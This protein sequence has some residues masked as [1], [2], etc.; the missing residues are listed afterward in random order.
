[1]EPVRLTIGRATPS[2]FHVLRAT[3]LRGRIFTDAEAPM[4]GVGAYPDPQVVILSWGLWQ[5]WYGGRDD[6]IG[7]ALRIDEMPVTIVGVMPR[8][9]AFPIPGARAWLP[10]PIGAVKDGK[11]LRLQ[12][13]GAL[14]RLAPQA[15][16][17]QA[18][19]E[20]TAR[21]R[22]APDPGMTAVAMFGSAAPSEISV[23]PAVAAMTADVRPAIILLFAAVALLLVTVTANVGSL[24][25]AR[26]TTRR[27]EVAVRAAIGAG[28]SRLLRQ[29]LTESAVIGC[30]GGLLGLA[31][32]VALVS[33]LPA[34]LPADFP[35]AREIAINL[36]VL[37]C[38]LAASLVVSAACALFPAAEASRVDLTAA[39]AGDSAASSG[40]AWRSRSG[41]LRTVIMAVQVAV[42]CLVLVG[43][44][45]L[46]RSF[47][48][49]MQADRGYD[50]VNV[51]TARVDLPRRYTG[52][53][54][55][56]FADAV[57]DRLGAAPGVVA[58]AAGNALPMVTVG[59]NFGFTMPSPQDPSLTLQV[60]TMVRH[61]SP[62]YFPAMRLRLLEGRL[63]SDADTMGTRPVV[64]VN[65]SFAQ[66]YL[67]ASPLGRHLPLSF[68]EGH[69]TCD[70]V[71]IV[72]DMRQG[73]VTEPRAAEV[74]ASY[75]QHPDRLAHAPLILLA[76]TA[77][78]PL[79]QVG[80]LREAVRVQDRSVALDSVMTLEERVTTSLA[81]PRI[82]AVLLGAFAVSALVVAAVG[83]FGVLS[84]AVAQRSR[85][86]GIRTALGARAV[87]V[88]RLVLRHAVLMASA[89]IAAGLAAAAVVVRLL[90]GFLFGVSTR[91]PLTFV[92]VPVLLLACAAIACVAPARRAAKVDPVTVL[93]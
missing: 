38:A 40:G 73:D 92:A 57:L 11:V 29:L 67:G 68:G 50:P 13:F 14:A 69:P 64:V 74:F 39:L 35:R 55:A 82:Y 33:A 75:R 62:G 37:G 87:D 88:V 27:R 9:F 84:Y 71:G 24:Q 42:A 86:I 89:G 45:L 81:K 63:L 17:A 36:P 16:P 23:T 78:D 65:R 53:L 25:L 58:A 60:Q 46:G 61:V 28:A 31:L 10:M 54:R 2:L 66:Q 47:L 34:I 77:G 18:A 56:A 12:I 21:A 43:A 49:M 32:S 59:S 76:R 19:S 8:D 79:A 30:S 20:A 5:E 90:S 70:V 6:A 26:A 15:T 72:D 52:P 3:P 80:A 51:L 93:R 83:L 48:S 41:R 7:A 1:M 91:D 22:S 4:G 44:S 85:E